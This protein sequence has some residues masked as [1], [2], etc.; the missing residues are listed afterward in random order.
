MTHFKCS[1]GSSNC[2]KCFEQ[3]IDDEV[4]DAKPLRMVF[5]TTPARPARPKNNA[6]WLLLFVFDDDILDDFFQD[7]RL[8]ILTK[9]KK[10][11][12]KGHEP[13]KEF[14]LSLIPT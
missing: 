13:E 12:A 5:L 11:A 7:E 8:Y 1:G 10:R 3:Y 9:R 2:V 4:L 14:F 6:F